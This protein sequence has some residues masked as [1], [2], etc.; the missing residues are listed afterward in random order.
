MDGV[1]RLLAPGGARARAQRGPVRAGREGRRG[2]ASRCCRCCWRAACARSR[3]RSSG[4]TCATGLMT[5]PCGACSTASTR[6]AEARRLAQATALYQGR[7]NDAA[8]RVPARPDVQRQLA[9]RACC[10][11][12]SSWPSALIAQFAPRFALAEAAAPDLPYWTDLG[13][14]MAPL[15]A[16]QAAAAGAGPA[17]LRRR[18]GARRSEGARRAHPRHRRRARE[19]EPGRA[20]DAPTRCSRCSSTWRCTGR[21]RPPE[22]KHQR[23]R[24]KSRLSVTNGLKGVIDILGE[25]SRSPSTAAARRAGSS[26]T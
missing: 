12:K 25:S 16:L 19:P 14:P 7:R 8:A 5:P 3:S 24:V 4:C 11:R 9:R 2:C 22:R 21:R 6:Y 18:R 17:L 1:A 13:Q 20:G 26:R 15:R 23:H 10:P